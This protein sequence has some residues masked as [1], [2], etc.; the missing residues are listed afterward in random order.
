[1][2]NVRNSSSELPSPL[3][4]ASALNLLLM[5]EDSGRLLEL[6]GTGHTVAGDITLN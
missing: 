5:S 1:M 6:V 2:S 3:E 4:F